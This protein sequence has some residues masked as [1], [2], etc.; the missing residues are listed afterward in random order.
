[1]KLVIPESVRK[2]AK[3][4]ADNGFQ[5]FLVGGA[6]RD[7]LLGRS[8]Q[9][10][11]IATDASPEKVMSIFRHVIPTGLKHGTVTVLTGDLHMEVTT[12]RKE[13]Q[14]TDFRRPDNVTWSNSIEED[15]CRRDFTINGM[16]Y[17]IMAKTLVDPF[18]GQKD[19]GDN[20]LRAIGIPIERFHEDPLRIMRACRFAS[21]LGFS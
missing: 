12:F 18:C 16:A 15:L 8:V 10:Y 3:V 7:S 13:D 21:Q 9:D 1:M 11:D 20:L 5:A 2:T 4:L 14:Y 17:D 19:I 6:V